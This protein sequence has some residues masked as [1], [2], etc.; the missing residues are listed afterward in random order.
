[1]S[2]EGAAIEP[3]ATPAGHTWTVL[4]AHRLPAM[5][6]CLAVSVALVWVRVGFSGSA[7]Y[8]F[9]PWNL[10]LAFVPYAASVAA[11]ALAARSP[12]VL[13]PLGVLGLLFLPNAFYVATDLVHFKARAPIPAWFDVGLLAM[14]AGTGWILGLL[15]MRVWKRLLVERFGAPFA[16]AAAGVSAALCGYGIYLGRFG[17]WNSWDVMRAPRAL[18]SDVASHLVPPW[19]LEVLGVTGLFGGL[20]LV[21]FVAFELDGG[22]RR[23]GRAD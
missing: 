5:G 18:V 17:R 22:A 13:L 3:R 20:I 2:P 11:A 19:N 4:K 15:A 23:A 9:L 21:T 8:S 6:L 10:F 16:W 1:M 14:A 12:R 7:S